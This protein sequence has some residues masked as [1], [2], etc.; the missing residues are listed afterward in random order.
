MLPQQSWGCRKVSHRV[1]SSPP[2]LWTDRPAC[3]G[4]GRGRRRAGLGSMWLQ[5][6]SSLLDLP[7]PRSWQRAQAD[8]RFL[9]LSSLRV[10]TG[11]PMWCQA[12]HGL[13]LGDMQSARRLSSDTGSLRASPDRSR[14][15]LPSPGRAGVS[16]S[17]PRP[18]SQLFHLD[19]QFPAFC[20]P[21]LGSPA[22]LQGL[23]GQVPVCMVGS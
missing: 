4:E 22:I 16:G 12:G 13:M 3:E 6:P 23:G 14:E 19:S 18:R 21:T 5:P 1:A 7:K 2:K 11:R 9:P 10:G 20:M 8:Y 15:A 17:V